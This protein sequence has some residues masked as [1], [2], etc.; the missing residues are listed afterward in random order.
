M[1]IRFIIVGIGVQRYADGI[2]VSF[3]IRHRKRLFPR[4]GQQKTGLRI[5]ACSAVGIGTVYPIVV[6]HA[7][8]HHQL[9][10][11]GIFG[12]RREIPFV[13]LEFDLKDG[14]DD[15]ARIDGACFD[16]LQ[17]FGDGAVVVRIF[18]Y[19]GGCAG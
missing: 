18:E 8:Q 10:A 6:V 14:M 9:V 3:Y 2:S 1:H 5:L 12:K 11:S 19:K 15:I 16:D 4:V 17:I 13:K 7:Y